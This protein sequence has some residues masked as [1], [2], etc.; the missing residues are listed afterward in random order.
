MTSLVT[1]T[2]H[3]TLDRNYQLKDLND[4]SVF[5]PVLNKFTHVHVCHN[6]CTEM[7]LKCT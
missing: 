1:T 2:G 6:S 4:V 5:L 7:H 3:L